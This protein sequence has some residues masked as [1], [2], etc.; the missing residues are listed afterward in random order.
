MNPD[1]I[2]LSVEVVGITAL[3]LS[4]AFVGFEIKQTRDMNLAQLQLNRLELFHNTMLAVL[5]SEPTL[6]HLGKT[7]YTEENGVS[8]K[9]EGLDD[10]QRAAALVLAEA[11][12]SAW[13]I[14][15]YIIEQGFDIRTAQDFESEIG[16]RFAQNPALEAVWP[17]WRY[18]GDEINT[19]YGIVN[20]ALSQQDS[21]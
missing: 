2:R 14:Q 20:R 17:L 21:R 15:S 13:E 11:Q 19:Y 9:N 5:E 6:I 3:V 18:P 8:W 16:A 10:V 7:Y 1:R 4:L 12:L